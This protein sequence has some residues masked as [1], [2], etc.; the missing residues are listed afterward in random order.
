MIELANIEAFRAG[1]KHLRST[2]STSNNWF[3]F[4]AI[5]GIILLFVGLHYWDKYRKKL[6]KQQSNSKSLFLELCEIHNLS[7]TERALLLKAGEIQQLTQ[8]ALV[9]V[10][11]G[12]L[13]GLEKSSQ[14]EASEFGKLSQKLFAQ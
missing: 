5:A 3:L 11:P 6:I 1:A 9:F 2:G 12:M 13:S 8:P 14:P 10:T 7:K 4:I